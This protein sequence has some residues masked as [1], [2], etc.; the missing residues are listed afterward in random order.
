MARTKKWNPIR[1]IP[2]NTLLLV[3]TVRGHEVHAKVLKSA[4]IMKADSRVEVARI[5]AIRVFPDSS[6]RKHGD[7]R[8]VGWRELR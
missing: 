6:W 1:G 3:K 7:V 5:P 2:R 4:K 8:A